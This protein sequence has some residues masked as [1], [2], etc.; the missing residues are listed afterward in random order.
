MRKPCGGGETLFDNGMVQA[1]IVLLLAL[2]KG[3]DLQ[4]AQKIRIKRGISQTWYRG[5]DLNL[6]ELAP[7][8]T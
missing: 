5:E 2:H 4:Y 8:S 6:H 3:Q 7:A 1:L